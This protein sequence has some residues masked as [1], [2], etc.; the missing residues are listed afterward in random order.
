M[1]VCKLI[2]VVRAVRRVAVARP[3]PV[4]A[5]AAAGAVV[6]R[7]PARLLLVCRDVG[8]AGML[9]AATAA[10]PLPEAA[11]ATA[12][13]AIE[14][15]FDQTQAAPWNGPWPGFPPING[16]LIADL[17]LAGPAPGPP[18]P[19]PMPRPN[20]EMPAPTPIAPPAPGVA[21]VPEPSSLALF[22]AGA[23]AAPWL[24]RRYARG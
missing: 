18:A 14:G 16:P 19:G 6:R 23:L 9:L 2:P 22:L 13:T 5:A 10:A 11:P 7:A 17:P 3:R 12:D 21:A 1:I 4:V 15:R 8:L 24:R 20:G